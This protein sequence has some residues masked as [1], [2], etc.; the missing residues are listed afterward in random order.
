MPRKKNKKSTVPTEID[1]ITCEVVHDA[2]NVIRNRLF[3]GEAPESL[4]GLEDSI[5]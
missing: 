5:S 1:E 2:V 4:H 3:N